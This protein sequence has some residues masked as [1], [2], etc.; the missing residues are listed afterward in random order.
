ML[1]SSLLH[2]IQSRR[3]I[4]R[5]TTQSVSRDVIEPL[6]AAA[7][8]SPSA[9]NRQP[10]RFVVIQ[11][12]VIKVRLA[13]AM[14]DRLRDDRLA[15]GDS[16]EAV[17][18]DSTRSY[19]RLTSSPVIL[20]VALTMIDMDRYPDTR[21]E[22]AEVTMAAQSVAMAAQNFLLAAHAAGFGAC[23]M[24]APL[25]CPD[26]VTEVLELP[27][28]WEPQ[29]LITLGYPANNGKPASRKNLEEV[30]IWR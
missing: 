23:W 20:L 21:R 15:D 11:D 7:I 12:D 28:D 9:H 16:L 3:S 30:V 17:E 27:K 26:V 18:A 6:L 8:W 22:K 2:V 5:Y 25:F 10:W 4:R 14:A 1:T 19:R 24:C 29:A 13:R